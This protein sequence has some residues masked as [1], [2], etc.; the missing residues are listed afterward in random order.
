M[1][2]SLV[3]RIGSAIF[4]RLPNNGARLGV[5]GILGFALGAAVGWLMGDGWSK[6]VT[7]GGVL[8]ALFMGGCGVAW[9]VE[10]Q[11]HRFGAS[12]YVLRLAMLLAL[13]SVAA[14]IIVLY[15]TAALEW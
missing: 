11:R 2:Q 15:G 1:P 10:A 3:I 4:E 9:T 7:F 14:L 5:C 13:S 8:C 12:S 6:A